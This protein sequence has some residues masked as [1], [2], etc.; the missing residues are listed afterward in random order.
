MNFIDILTKVGKIASEVMYSTIDRGIRISPEKITEFTTDQ[1]ELLCTKGN[2]NTRDL[3]K[4]E[5]LKRK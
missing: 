3:A 1:L 5:L 4:R 2:P